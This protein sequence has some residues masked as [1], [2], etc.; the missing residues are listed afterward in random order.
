MRGTDD[1]LAAL[2]GGLLGPLGPL[3]RLGPR[4]ALGTRHRGDECEVFAR[5]P[6]HAALQRLGVELLLVLHEALVARIRGK[7]LEGAGNG[8]RVGLGDGTQRDLAAV[9]QAQPARPIG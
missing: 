2:P 8:R 1:F 4:R 7:L 6:P 9:A 3:D 5:P